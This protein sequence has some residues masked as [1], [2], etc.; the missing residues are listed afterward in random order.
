[1]VI[2]LGV[3]VHRYLSMHAKYEGSV[4]YGVDEC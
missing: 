1:M 3:I 4:S 2:D